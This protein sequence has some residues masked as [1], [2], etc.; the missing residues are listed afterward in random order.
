S[1]TML[2][3]F[4]RQVSGSANFWLSRNR[5]AVESQRNALAT[6]SRALTKQRS[7]DLQNMEKVISLLS[8]LQVL[9][10]GYSFT[11]V[12]GKLVTTINGIIKGD[13]IITVVSDGSI[14]S[15]VTSTNSNKES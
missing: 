12:N 1:Y 15:T 8:P 4:T 10:R 9:K 2:N 14:A 11:T 6:G 7:R 3:Q 13:K 5:D